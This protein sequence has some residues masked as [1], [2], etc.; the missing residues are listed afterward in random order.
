MIEIL[1]TIFIIFVIAISSIQD[2]E[3]AKIDIFKSM[4]KHHE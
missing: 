1:F 2:E 4:R 3:N